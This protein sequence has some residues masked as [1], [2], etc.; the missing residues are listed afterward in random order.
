MKQMENE[1]IRVQLVSHGL[2]AYQK[3]FEGSAKAEAAARQ[4]AGGAAASR[5]ENKG[6]DILRFEGQGCV[7][8]AFRLLPQELSVPV[9]EYLFH[10]EG[11]GREVWQAGV[12]EKA[13]YSAVWAGLS[14]EERDHVAQMECID[15]RAVA[16]QR[17]LDVPQIVW[18]DV[19]GE[20]HVA[21]VDGVQIGSVERGMFSGDY[22]VCLYLSA[23]SMG[24][25]TADRDEVPTLEAGK[26]R[27]R[28]MVE[29]ALAKRTPSAVLAVVERTPAGADAPDNLGWLCDEAHELRKVK[30]E[31][32]G[33]YSPEDLDAWED[34]LAV[35]AMTISLLKD[36]HPSFYQQLQQRARNLVDLNRESFDVKERERDA[37]GAGLGL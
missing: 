22:T 20:L 7:I 1:Q 8:R 27:L 4:L 36:C 29:T 21:K 33:D 12:S 16:Q 37:H 25:E 28:E 35:A 14:H 3:D 6:S 17:S 13:A 34:R 24:S 19:D 2:P 30:T 32:N 31:L 18:E 11:L 23:A 9:R 15:E 5:V 26:A 10:I